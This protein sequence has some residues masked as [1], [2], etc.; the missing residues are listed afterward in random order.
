[1]YEYRNECNLSWGDY[2]MIQSLILQYYHLGMTFKLHD[3][4][5]NEPSL[6][7]T[8]FYLYFYT[9]DYFR[10]SGLREMADAVNR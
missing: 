1:M 10:W 7:H 6:V 3:N 2:F 4:F 5:K 9:L 8:Y